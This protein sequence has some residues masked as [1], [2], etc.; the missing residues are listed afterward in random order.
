LEQIVKI[1][2]INPI[3]FSSFLEAFNKVLPPEIRCIDI[4]PCDGLFKPA[5]QALSKEYR[6]FITNKKIVSNNEQ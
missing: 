6:Y 5:A 3:E 4:E 2:S 1:S